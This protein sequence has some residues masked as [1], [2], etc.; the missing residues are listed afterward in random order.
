MCN[1]VK[2]RLKVNNLYNIL[3]NKAGIHSKIMFN[4]EKYSTKY[5]G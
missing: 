3:I 2:Y 4:I 1:I 5:I